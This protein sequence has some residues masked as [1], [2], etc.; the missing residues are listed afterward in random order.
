MLIKKSTPIKH[1]PT[2]IVTGFLGVGK[3]TT[4]LNLLQQKPDNERWAILVN[5]F[6]EI[7]VD[8]GLMSG[9]FSE[10][11]GTF[12][13]EVPGGCMCCAA[14]LP[15]Q[16]ALNQLLQ[17][18]RP[19]RLIIEPTG[20]GH[21]IEVLQTLTA[22]HYQDIL[23]I[24]K[25]ITLVD[26]RKLSDPRYRENSTFMQQIAIADSVIGN[27]Q[28][29]Y[30]KQDKQQ[31]IEFTK[32]HSNG[33]ASLGFCTQGNFP[34]AVLEGRTETTAKQSHHHHHS[35]PA[36]LI[37]EQPIPDSG[38]LKAENSGEGYQSIGWRF[39]PTHVFSKSKLYA[40]LTGLIAERMKA[41]FIT[42]EGVFGYNMTPDTLTEIELDDCS[43]SRIEII[44]EQP[45][46]GWEEDILACLIKA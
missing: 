23:D 40:L 31:L 18:A 43:E 39:S 17:R 22:S 36:P 6:G 16:I 12:I 10:E 34:L 4:I 14:G 25:I 35:E 15:M 33:Y 24:N 27:K 20:L 19:D 13:R 44:C 2:N 26:A 28:D 11:Q 38:Y 37:S 3:T 30:S 45:L 21:P 7:G 8:G 29:L 1:V 5:E 9:Q 41:V 42:D 32:E 46:E